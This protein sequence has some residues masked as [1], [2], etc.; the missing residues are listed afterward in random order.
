MFEKQ[1]TL[2]YSFLMHT[3]TVETAPDGVDVRPSLVIVDEQREHFPSLFPDALA[4]TTHGQTP[5]HQKQLRPLQ[6]VVYPN[7][8]PNSTLSP[9]CAN[10]R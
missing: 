5:S 4:P 10:S 8:N 3:S 6:D 1:S 9:L 7:N 2:K